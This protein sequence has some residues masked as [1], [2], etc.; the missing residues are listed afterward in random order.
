MGTRE[1]IFPRE[2]NNDYRGSPISCYVLCALAAM[3][4]GSL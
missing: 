3:F 2:A 1:R 4:I